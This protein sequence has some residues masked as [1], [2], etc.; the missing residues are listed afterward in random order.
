MKQCPRCSSENVGAYK[1]AV[2][3]NECNYNIDL[4]VN[5]WSSELK[6]RPTLSL[7]IQYMISIVGI[8][9]SGISASICFGVLI[10]SSV[11]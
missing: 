3:C 10:F 11:T 7:D 4:L 6:D 8:I 1:T 9:V 5:T 2:W